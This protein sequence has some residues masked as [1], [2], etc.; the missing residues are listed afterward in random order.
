VRLLRIITRLN[1]GGPS[2][3]VLQLAHGLEG[4]GIRTLL[5]HG[6]SEADEG[7]LAGR[8]E[9]R[10]IE[11][12]RIPEL[13]RAVSPGGEGAALRG[14]LR[15]LRRFEPQIVHTHL[16]K[17]GALGR[18]AARIS[19]TPAVF[20]TFHGHVF[21]GYFPGAV[22]RAIVRAERG[23]ARWTDRILVPGETVRGEILRHRIAPATRVLAYPPSVDWEEFDRDAGAPDPAASHGLTSLRLDGI[24]GP[25][26]GVVG[27]L[28]PIKGHTTLFHAAALLAAQGAR[29]RLV[30]A[31]DGPERGAL[32]ALAARLGLGDRIRFVGFVRNRAALYRNLDLLVLPSESEGVPVALL[33]GMAAGVPVVATTVGGIPEV[34]ESGR[35]GLLVAPSDPVALAGALLALVDSPATLREMGRRAAEGARERFDPKKTMVFLVDL[36]LRT[37]REKRAR[38]RAGGHRGAPARRFED[39]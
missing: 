27:R 21:S 19:R 22:S 28:V 4:F 7:S 1:V 17:A 3:H 26:L 36:Y 16:A 14:I 33:E 31:G 38:R 23:L 35:T 13:R 37:L 29:F 34:V 25:V 9:E 5:L 10:G 8:L 11:H 2:F 18:L 15:E 32:E 20:H 12:R 30:V 39:R 24:G 6:S